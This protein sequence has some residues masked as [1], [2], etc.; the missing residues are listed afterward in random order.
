MKLLR[1]YPGYWVCGSLAILGCIILLLSTGQGIGLSP[2]SVVY[3]DA[4][5]GLLNGHGFRVPSDTGEWTPVVYYPPLFSTLL[6]GIGLLGTD[7]VQGAR[8]LNA[9]LFGSNI[10]LG[11]LFFHAA[12]RSFLISL[13]ASLVMLISFPVVFIHSMAWSEPLFIF[14]GMLSIFLLALSVEKAGGP[15]L[16]MASAS[17]GLAFLTRYAGLAFVV[18]GMLAIALFASQPW[19]KRLLHA[20]AFG[21]AGC[22]PVFLWITGNVWLTGEAAGRKI[23]FH[24]LGIGHWESF[25]DTVAAWLLPAGNLPLARGLSLLVTAILGLIYRLGSMG[26]VPASAERLQRL[27]QLLGL[28]SV[29]YGALLVLSISFLDVQTPLDNRILSPLYVAAVLFI[30]CLAQRLLCAPKWKARRLSALFVGLVLVFLCGS[31]LMQTASWLQYSSS[32]GVGY[33]SSEW[34]HSPVIKYLEGLG[35]E[36]PV[37]TNGPD[38]IRLLTGRSAAMI[39]RKIDPDTAA[40]NSRYNDQLAAMGRLIREKQ[41][42]VVY[43]SRIRWRWYLA[44]EAEINEQLTLTLILKTEDGAVYQ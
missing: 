37:F 21:L 25:M 15:V 32:H 33:A 35:P 14:L 34:R 29:T 36:V 1:A 22:A 6:A 41:G 17:A 30:L 43:F 3:I 18:T 31:Q 7:P 16:M 2:D 27:P 10:L 26:R 24:P 28:F 38:I 23:A 19:R 42:V 12:G 9:A 8:W 40:P 5:R 11:G 44:T 13:S 20:G 4:S 39:P